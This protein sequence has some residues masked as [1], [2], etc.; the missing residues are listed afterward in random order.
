MPYLTVESR[1]KAA[2]V[3][4]PHITTAIRVSLATNRSMVF[5]PASTRYIVI[6]AAVISSTA[7]IVQMAVTVLPPGRP[8]ATRARVRTR[9]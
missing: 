9:R 6:E 3:A 2:Q 4:R 8:A 7:L 1:L 5:G